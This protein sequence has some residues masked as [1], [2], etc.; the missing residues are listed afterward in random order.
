MITNTKKKVTLKAVNPNAGIA[1]AYKKEL[2]AI[3]DNMHN[4]VLYWIKSGFRKNSPV[5]SNLTNDASP[6]VNLLRII[7]KLTRRW[8]KE[9]DS[10]A[11][12]I[13]NKYILKTFNASQ[14]SLENNLKDNGFAVEFKMTRAMQDALS[15]SIGENVGLIKSIPEQYFNQIESAVMRTYASGGDLQAL[16]KL[17]DNIYP[18]AK[19]RVSLIARDQT[20]KANAVTQRTRQLELGITQAIWMHSHGGKEPRQDHVAANGKVY[21]I[22]KGCLISGKY[23][24]PGE[25]INCRCTSRPILPI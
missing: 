25:E 1:A 18:K 14:N 21:D 7:N 15:A 5:V 12:E 22:K 24:F 19:N 8:S 3:V 20:N 16:V 10:M 13:A 6:S 11:N 4:S 9:F 2:Q 23:I 17:L